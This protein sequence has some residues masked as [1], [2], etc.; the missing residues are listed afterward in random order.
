MRRAEAG[1]MAKKCGAEKWD[2]IFCPTFFALIQVIKETQ[3]SV[4][5]VPS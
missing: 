4:F 5:K 1:E 3:S 2:R